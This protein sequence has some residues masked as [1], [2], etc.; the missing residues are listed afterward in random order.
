MREP[1]CR[2]EGV[3]A[4]LT[5]T[6]R[7]FAALTA[8]TIPLS[9]LARPARAQAAGKGGPLKIGLVVPLSGPLA[10]FGGFA[11]HGAELA[12]K[13]INA[14]GG[15]NGAPMELL[16]GDSQGTPVEAV[17]A[18]RRVISDD[19]V[20]VILG[21]IASSAT[22]ALQPVVEEAQVILLNA[23]SSNPDITYKAGVGGYKWSFRSYPTDELRAKVILQY[24][25]EQKHFTRY[26]VLSVDSDFGRGAIAFSKKYLPQFHG[27]ILSEDYYKDDETDFRPVL[28]HIKSL[29]VQGI[30]SYGLPDAT[31]L[32][33][34]QIL[35]LGLA[36]KV[37]LLGS[38]EFTYPDTIKVSQAVLNGAVE[39]SA[40][41]PDLDNPRSLKFVED[42]RTA[43]GA[44]EVPN[45]HSYTHWEAVY[46]LAA[47]AKAAGGTES[48]ALR[49]ALEAIDYDG[50]TGK[51]RFDS[52]HQAELPMFIYQV[53]GGKAVEKGAFVAKVEYPA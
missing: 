5:L 42:Y 26:A 37:A 40:W 32:I 45:V 44:K 53:D 43:Y 19:K 7:Q 15:V 50:A 46:L 4:M 35:E 52:H 41:A 38:G 39:A 36:G 51:I 20:Q 49:S 23:A 11:S 27:E 28:S 30:L 21:D 29:D 3:V 22:I 9:T 34:R 18:A 33:V 6:R 31:R 8:A 2:T 12:V 10:R 48:T 47:A 25:A 24:G 16:R 1:A 17:S 14:A 13:Q